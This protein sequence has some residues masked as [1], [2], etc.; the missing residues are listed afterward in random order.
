MLRKVLLNFCLSPKNILFLDFRLDFLPTFG[1][2]FLDTVLLPLTISV[3]LL[4]RKKTFLFHLVPLHN[5]RSMTDLETTIACPT[6][7][8][9]KAPIVMKFRF[10]EATNM[11]PKRISN[12]IIS[13]SNYHINE[14]LCGQKSIIIPTSPRP[15]VNQVR[16]S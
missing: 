6:R 16:K 2:I 7:S 15:F 11:I 9:P 8:A 3:P 1:L 5:F 10:A 14:F 12:L 4:A 13:Q